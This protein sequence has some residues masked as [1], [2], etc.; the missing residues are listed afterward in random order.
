MENSF[1]DPI[2][3]LWPVTF[4][5][6]A[7]FP[8]GRLGRRGRPWSAVVAAAS[9]LLAVAPL[10]FAVPVSCGD[11]TAGLDLSP[12]PLGVG[13][14]GI[15]AWLAVVTRLRVAAGEDRPKVER[16]VLWVAA[17]LVPL[18]FVELIASAVTLAVYCGEGENASRLAHLGV[19]AVVF[20]LSTAA[21]AGA[22]SD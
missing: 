10:T 4:A 17:T 22:P 1:A 8:A 18:G 6:L 12:I 13:L 11:D 19:A 21:G 3:F 16:G 5:L 15:V 2:W 9:V 14:L 20:V 7:G